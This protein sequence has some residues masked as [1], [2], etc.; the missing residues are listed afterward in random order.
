VM[1]AWFYRDAELACNGGRRRI[2]LRG[3]DGGEE[4]VVVA[5]FDGAAIGLDEV[6]DLKGGG[7][8]VEGDPVT[9]GVGG[10][11]DAAHADHAVADIAEMRTES[12]PAG[13]LSAPGAVDVISGKGIAGIREASSAVAKFFLKEGAEGAGEEVGGSVGVAKL[14]DADELGFRVGFE[15][16]ELGEE[17]LERAR[18]FDTDAGAGERLLDAVD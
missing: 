3:G 18:I 17:R 1:R 13:G 9:W 6:L 15:L 10:E 8:G 11:A 7:V 5:D 2:G 12:E 4:C 14:N 16:V